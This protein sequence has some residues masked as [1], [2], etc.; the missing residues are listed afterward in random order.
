MVF[1]LS[2]GESYTTLFTTLGT[3]IFHPVICYSFARLI[4]HC[5]VEDTALCITNIHRLVVPEVELWI[6]ISDISTWDR[7]SSYP[8]YLTEAVTY[9]LYM[10]HIGCQVHSMVLI[11]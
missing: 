4:C 5:P 6:M 8:C 10:G 7:N 11:I 9:G 1:S 3:L 2:E